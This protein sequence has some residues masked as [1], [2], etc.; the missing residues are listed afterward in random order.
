MWFRKCAGEATPTATWFLRARNATRTSW[1]RGRRIFCD[2]CSARAIDRGGTERAAAG[3]GGPGCGE[4]EADVGEMKWLTKERTRGKNPREAA[5]ISQARARK[6]PNHSNTLAR[7]PVTAPIYSKMDER[8]GKT[9]RR[10]AASIS[11]DG[12]G[13]L[14]LSHHIRT[15]TNV[16]TRK[17]LKSSGETAPSPRFRRCHSS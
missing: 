7:S 11:F 17:W 12:I 5:R 1:T 15:E 8:Q 10:Y 4:D 14:E 3:A 9:R 16:D 6:G 2:G 13:F